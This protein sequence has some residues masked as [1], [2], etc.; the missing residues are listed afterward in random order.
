MHGHISVER[1][2]FGW[3]M[4]QGGGAFYPDQMLPPRLAPGSEFGQS[5]TSA[6][7]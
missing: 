1:R 7:L 5:L 3:R 6:E 2:G 4:P